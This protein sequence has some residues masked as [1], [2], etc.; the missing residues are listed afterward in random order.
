MWHIEAGVVKHGVTC[1][2]SPRTP[3]GYTAAALQ[4]QQRQHIPVHIS[5]TRLIIQLSWMNIGMEVP[6]FN[7]IS[8]VNA[9]E[10]VQTFQ[11]N[12]K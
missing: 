3:A 11:E 12:V 5:Q 9:G 1:I 2:K 7:R 4:I 10:N 6:S 8:T